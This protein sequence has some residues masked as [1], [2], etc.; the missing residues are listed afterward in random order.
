MASGGYGGHRSQ[1]LL[2]TL[3]NILQRSYFV[4]VSAPIGEKV[5]G[6]WGKTR[7]AEGKPGNH[8]DHEHGEHAGSVVFGI[9]MDDPHPVWQKC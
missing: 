1:Q 7:V 3:T 5:F 4:A 2:P 9:Q 6:M 8:G